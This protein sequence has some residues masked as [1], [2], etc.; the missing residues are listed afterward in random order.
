MTNTE[1]RQ[2]NVRHYE[3]RLQG[4]LD[5]RRLRRFE[6][7]QGALLATGETL[8]TGPIVDQAALHSILR[9]INDMGMPLLE[10]RCVG[11]TE[12][13]EACQDE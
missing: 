8:L 6:G 1:A 9:R 10:L 12:Q 7:L 5:E 2:P 13:G 3:I 4:H 11:D